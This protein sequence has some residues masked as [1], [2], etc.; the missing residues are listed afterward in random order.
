MTTANT[1]TS[2]AYATCPKCYGVKRFGT[3]AH[4]QNG[5]C[6]RCAG[7]GT[8][9]RSSVHATAPTKGPAYKSI[10]LPSFGPASICRFGAGFQLSYGGQ[11]DEGYRGG[12][13]VF[14]I[15]DGRVVNAT[16]SDAARRRGDSA[17]LIREIQAAVKY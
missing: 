2:S 14:D 9:L 4:I 8:V 11:T 5:D 13:V 6:F 16:V 17:A 12:Q 10:T 7:N 3:F 15:V 1:N